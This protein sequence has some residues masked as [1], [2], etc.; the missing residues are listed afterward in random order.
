MKKAGDTNVTILRYQVVN[1]SVNML[2]TCKGFSLKG[3]PNSADCHVLKWSVN[4][5]EYNKGL[6]LN[7]YTFASVF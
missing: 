1:L 4:T 5:Y 3:R 6:Y 2:A 7:R